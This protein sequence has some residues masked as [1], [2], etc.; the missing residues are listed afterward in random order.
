MEMGVLK[1]SM[2]VRLFL[3]FI[4][5]K[6]QI[7]NLINMNLFQVIIGDDRVVR[8]RRDLHLE[9]LAR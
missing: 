5:I 1:N 9:S 7:N 6:L 3:N 2:F 8:K 4:E